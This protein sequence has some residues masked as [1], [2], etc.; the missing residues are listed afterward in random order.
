MRTKQTL[1]AAGNRIG[2]FLSIWTGPGILLFPIIS[3]AQIYVVNDSTGTIGEYTMSG[4]AINATLVKGLSYP[5]ALATDGQGHLFVVN[6]GSDNVGEYTTSGAVVNASLPFFGYGIACDG[7]GN[8]FVAQDGT[9]GEYTTSGATVNALLIEKLGTCKGGIALDGNGNLFVQYEPSPANTDTIGEWTTSG[10]IVNPAVISGN[11]NSEIQY[12]GNGNLY[13]LNGNLNGVSEY[14]TSGATVNASL[15]T[16]LTNALGLALDGNG[17]LFVSHTSGTSGY[18][19]EYTTA[20][21]AVNATLISG[22]HNPAGIVVLPQTVPS[23]TIQVA[24]QS[25]LLI[26]WPN[27]GSYTLQSNSDLS[28]SAWSP[29]NG[30]VTTSNGTNSVTITPAAQSAFFRIESP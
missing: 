18:V 28:T 8:I 6:T 29:Y 26:S 27:T 23:P 10:G 19:G 16:G 30:T 14:T 1:L 5:T 20:G 25:S 22:L 4:S 2:R 3:P 17:H 24:S 12:D 7:K 15:I 11:G 13:M 9:V 21:V